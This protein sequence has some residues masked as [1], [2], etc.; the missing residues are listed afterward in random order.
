[1]L[2][3]EASGAS[4]LIATDL[5]ADDVKANASG[6][7]TIEVTA[8]RELAADASGASSIRYGGSPEKVKPNASGASTVGPK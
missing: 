3:A 6:A 5:I 1:M 8:I 4:R 2:N 7:S